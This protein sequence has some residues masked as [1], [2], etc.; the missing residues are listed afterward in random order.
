MLVERIHLANSW[1]RHV[2]IFEN[3]GDMMAE[4]PTALPDLGE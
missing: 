1:I 2:Q 3:R 4:H